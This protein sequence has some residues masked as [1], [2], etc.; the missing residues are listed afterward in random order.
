MSALPFALILL[1]ASPPGPAPDLS[2]DRVAAV[3]APYLEAHP[4]AAVTVGVSTP[5]GRAVYGFG[6][7]KAA[8]E[9]VVAPDGRTIYEL[10]SITK[11]FTGLTLARMIDAGVVSEDDLAAD[12]LPPDLAPP[13]WTD[14]EGVPRPIT[15]RQLATHTSGLPR[16]PTGLGLYALLVG[17]AGDPYAGFDR[18]LLGLTMRK[19]AP[20]EPGRFAY[21]NLGVGLL[22]HALAQVDCGDASAESTLLRNRLTGPLKL[23]DVAF[24]LSEEQTTRFPQT[25]RLGGVATTPWTFATIRACGGLHGTADDLLT[26][27]DAC[28]GR[29]PIDLSEAFR[30]AAEPREPAGNSRIGLCWL[31]S[32]LPTGRMVWHNGGTYGSASFLGLLP[33]RGIAVVVLSNCGASVDPLATALLKGADAP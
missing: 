23:K 33:D 1:A 31:T 12:R 15:L 5:A 30:T 22:G 32:E 17:D 11:A 9:P 10:G 7:V 18:P 24:D 19:M 26:L 14:E 16:L 20:K 21:S 3:V 29:G 4:Y 27:S 25:Y 13:V 2:A 6:S 8:E 28:L